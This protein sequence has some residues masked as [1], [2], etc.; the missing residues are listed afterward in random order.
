MTTRPLPPVSHS[1]GKALNSQP[2]DPS[3][4]APTSDNELSR[5]LGLRPT[6]KRFALSRSKWYLGFHI[7]SPTQGGFPVKFVSRQGDV[8]LEAVDAVP[9]GCTPVPPVQ[10]RLILAWGEVTGHHHSVP[11]G[12]ATLVKDREGTMYLT[13]DELTAVRHQTHFAGDVTPGTYRVRIQREYTS[14]D[15]PPRQVLD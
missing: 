1:G 15:M 9:E 3:M 14:K 12:V 8:G 11:A 5:K 10:G 13:V 6:S 2:R 7:C 4:T